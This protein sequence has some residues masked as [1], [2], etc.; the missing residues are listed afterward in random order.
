MGQ[1]V[2]CE[3]IVEHTWS[4]FSVGEVLVDICFEV[5]LDDRHSVK[6]LEGDFSLRNCGLCISARIVN[7]VIKLYQDG[8][9]TFVNRIELFERFHHLVGLKPVQAHTTQS[10]VAELAVTSQLS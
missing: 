5:M 3:G 10:L 1:E 6:E 4:S 9:V 2:D 7:H 8:Y